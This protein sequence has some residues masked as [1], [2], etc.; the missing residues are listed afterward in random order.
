LVHSPVGVAVG[1]R[2]AA[3]LSN[4]DTGS[5][6][7]ATAMAE[8]ITGGKCNFLRVDYLLGEICDIRGGAR[9]GKDPWLN[10]SEGGAG[11]RDGRPNPTQSCCRWSSRTTCSNGAGKETVTPAAAGLAAWDFQRQRQTGSRRE[12]DVERRLQA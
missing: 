12:A 7:H 11:G 3:R 6:L 4:I 1:C 8:W 10:N 5:A 2:G 9:G